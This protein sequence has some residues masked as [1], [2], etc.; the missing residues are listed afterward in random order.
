MDEKLEKVE[1]VAEMTGASYADARAALEETGW[2]MLSAVVLLE[3]QGKAERRTARC[4]TGKDGE[5]TGISAEMA[6]TQKQWRQDTRKVGVSEG[7]AAAWRKVRD[8]LLVK[9]IVERD[10]TQLAVIPM[11]LV[12]VALL[13]LHCVALVAVLV[14]LFFGVRYRFDGLDA[15]T[16]DVNDAMG[17]VA[18]MAESVAQNIG[19]AASA[20]D[21]GAQGE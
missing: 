2:D 5:D 13:V 17:K 4:S 8:F 12:I 1:R 18:D 15:V 6:R 3:E 14:S 11:F 16:I 10:G 21:E 20:D 7:A 9:L 19:D